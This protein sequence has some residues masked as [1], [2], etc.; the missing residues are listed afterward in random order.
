MKLIKLISRILLGITFVFSGFVKGIDP[1]GSA[2]KFTDYFEAFGWEALVVTALPL[3]FILS[4]AEFIIGIAL[5]FNLHTKRSAG[6]ALLFMLFFTPLTLYIALNNPVSDCGCFGDALKLTNWQ[7]FYKNLVF[8]ALA[9]ITFRNRKQFHSILNGKLQ[10]TV[11]L[12]FTVVFTI[13]SYV[14]FNHLPLIDFRP[15][16]E[17]VNIN[18]SMAVPADAQKPVY[19][20]I[21]HYKNLKT[22]QVK[23][24]T[25]QNYPWQDTLNWKFEKMDEPR[26]I[27]PGYVPPINNFSIETADGN[28]VKDF[29][30][31]EDN[32]TFF[33]IA[34]DL[35]KASD[36]SMKTIRELIKYCNEKNYNFI[37]LTASLQNEI[38]AFK[39]QHQLQFDF[40]FT[41]PITLK[42]MV[43]SNPGLMLTK[44]GTIVKKW[45]FND[46]PS[47]NSLEK[48]IK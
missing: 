37:G 30:L 48:V 9:I 45:H 5:L 15:Y 10:T 36:K 12:F 23:Q 42:T 24:F 32:Y 11:L 38:D 28:D 47:I 6:P 4:Y 17:G 41:D 39:A 13:L 18:E 7:T 19:E 27:T 26:L 20:N 40:L 31:D 33:Y 46:F 44:K 29:F 34:Y 2:Y 25:E 3:A 21:F 8:I 43:R 16:A 1:W 22:G 35:S 14:S